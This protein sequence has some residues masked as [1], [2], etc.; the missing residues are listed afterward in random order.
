MRK[1]LKKK[2]KA[3]A[4]KQKA[5]ITFIPNWYT[6]YPDLQHDFKFKNRQNPITF[7][8]LHSQKFIECW[9]QS[10]SYYEK[11]WRKYNFFKIFFFFFFLNWTFSLLSLCSPTVQCLELGRT[12]SCEFIMVTYW[13]KQDASGLSTS[14]YLK[15]RWPLLAGFSNCP[16]AT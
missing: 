11:M 9:S 8:Q 4:R 7:L 6:H 14:R 5:C 10:G 16:Q 2:K 13:C 3:K 12:L 15:V 1:G